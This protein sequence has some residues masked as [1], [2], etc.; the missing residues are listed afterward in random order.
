[1]QIEQRQ[2][3]GDLRGLA[4][5]RR[6]NHRGEPPPLAAGLLD[7]LVV[8]PRGADLQR[9]S[10]GRHLTRLVVAVTHHQ[11]VALL[12]QRAAVRLDVGGDLSLQRAAASMR[13]A[14]S[15]AISSSSERPAPADSPSPPDPVATVSMACLPDQRLPAPALLDPRQ[16]TSGRYASQVI[17]RSQALPVGHTRSEPPATAPCCVAGCFHGASHRGGDGHTCIA[18]YC[19]AQQKAEQQ[20]QQRAEAA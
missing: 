14:P 13:R 16:V 5:P 15:R 7:T 19:S 3:L 4:A 6:Q 17:H 8:D 18:K 12:V 11:A 20:P 9:P 10:R 2:H 1:M